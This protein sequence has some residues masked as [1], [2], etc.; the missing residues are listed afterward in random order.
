MFTEGAARIVHAAKGHARAQKRT[1]I[2]LASFLAATVADG[3][4]RTRLAEC[5]GVPTRTLQQAVPECLGPADADGPPMNLAASA[6]SFVKQCTAL[7]GAQGVP[8]QTHPGWINTAHLVCALAMAA[9][10]AALPE[11]CTPLSREEALTWLDRWQASQASAPSLPE[12]VGRLR[13]LR[14]EL[15]AQ[16][17]G[18][19]HAIQTFVEGLCNAELTAGADRQRAAPRAVFV[20]AG[21]PGVGK[22]YLAQLA[23]ACLGR[24]FKR[25]DM[26][27]YTDH[28]AHNQLVGFAPSF[29]DAHAGLLTGFVAE[30]PDAVLLF[31][32]VEKAHL[33][34]IQFFYQ[35]LDAGHLE[36]KFTEEDVPFRDTT[37]IFTTN[38]GRTLYDDANRA[39]AGVHRRTLLS[40]LA[41]ERNPS[42]GRPAFPPA[43]C[44]RL[45]QGYPVLFNHLGIND[46]ERVVATELTRTETLLEWQYG[47]PIG[48]DPLLPLILVLRAGTGADA[49]QLRAEAETFL[50]AE[51]YRFAGLYATERLAEVFA[52]IESIRLESESDP[53]LPEGIV[54]FFHPVERPRVLL[55][56]A[57]A[58]AER[59]RQQLPEVEWL[60]AA[61]ETSLAEALGGQEVDLV[62]LDLW[63][64]SAP[65]TSDALQTIQPDQDGVQFS[66]RAL[67]A[68]R[69]LLAL[70]HERFP[71]TPVYLLSQAMRHGAA[72]A[73]GRRVDEELFQAAV[74]AGGV[75]GVLDTDLGTAT[76]DSES[77][78]DFAHAVVEV[79]RRLRREAQGRALARERQ[80]LTFD[81]V[82]HLDRE[83][84]ELRIRLRDF[85]LCRAVEAGDVGELVDDVARPGFGFDR[86]LGAA[87]AKDALG[88]V[89]DWL[90][91]P[92]RFAAQGVRPPKGIL[93]AGP[94][95]TGKTLLAR[96]VAGESSCAFLETSASTFITK[97][98]G[99]GPENV[100]QLFGRARRYAPAIVFVDEIDSIGLARQGGMGHRSEEETLNAILTEMDGFGSAGASPVIVLAA[101]NLPEQLD[102]ALRRRFDRVIEVERPDRATRRQYLAQALLE[103]EGSALTPAV[104]DRLAGQSA[105]MTLAELE[106]VVHEAAVTAAQRR[107][108][109]ADSILEEAFE[110]IRMGSAKAMPDPATLERIAWHE[111]GH[112]LV[113]WRQG[114]RP[115]QVTIVGRG[116]AGGY[117]ERESAEEALLFTRRELQERLR[118]TLGGRAAEVLH[119]GPEEGLSTGVSGDLQ[120][121]SRLA[122]QMVCRYGMGESQGLLALPESAPPPPEAL[123]EANAILQAEL[124][125]AL[126]LLRAD[127]DRLE[128]L[129]TALLERNRLTGEAMDAVL[130]G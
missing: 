2:D 127:A 78:A 64:G 111:A 125:A 43:I 76:A 13:A 95:G 121:A 103:R 46:L 106:R 21:P 38:A 73:T 83:R 104:V 123:R 98:V 23:A 124:E 109:L 81:S 126:V 52:A 63:L 5:T 99:S 116:G 120:Q 118:E 19:D 7:A 113:A 101:T 27:G 56:A 58:L 35:V 67:Q 71:E 90:R 112:A 66:A 65:A 115:V 3:E 85:R 51:L 114:H 6:R 79:A 34:T 25:F 62:L 84:R 45:A 130:A 8:D 108:P 9:R 37:I 105:G 68:G 44:S 41:A 30:H 61:D 26:T 97:W 53:D 12:L 72:L 129:A 16:V 82:A 128:R 86:V 60:A 57:P 69:R 11:A 39:G 50:K 92:K 54:E 77:R 110:S 70:L 29:K 17:F 22:T 88:F 102:P 59:Y 93:L 94:P 14:A 28:Q 47:K 40:A 55:A 75:R 33:N 42:D 32:E 100:R 48:H 74:R 87:A 36:D 96:A 107:S 122:L 49:R 119:Y 80:T 31:D 15:Q 89:V 18:Q 20:F 1:T 91:E 4:A 24:P 117:M 10:E